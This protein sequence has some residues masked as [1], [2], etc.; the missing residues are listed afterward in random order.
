MA[1]ACAAEAALLASMTGGEGE[2]GEGRG[3]ELCRRVRAA[4]GV[5]LTGQVRHA[6]FW[7]RGC[8]QGEDGS[9]LGYGVPSADRTIEAG[10]ERDRGNKNLRPRPRPLWRRC[11]HVLHPPRT[12]TADAHRHTTTTVATA[13]ATT[14][15][16]GLTSA[17]SPLRTADGH[18]RGPPLI[19]IPCLGRLGRLGKNFPV[20]P[21]GPDFCLWSIIQGAKDQH[22]RA[23]RLHGMCA[24]AFSSGRQKP[25]ARRPRQPAVLRSCASPRTQSQGTHRAIYCNKNR[26]GGEGCRRGLA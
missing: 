25:S 16:T 19:S 20:F 23:E 21:P 12:P 3:R 14:A 17:T 24:T 26:S 15:T 4:G 7:R 6:D 2:E 11:T 10:R 13:A 22:A 9:R 1:S 18:P 5:L 8:R